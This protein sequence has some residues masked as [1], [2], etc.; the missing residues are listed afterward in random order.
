MR[1]KVKVSK[2]G[3]HTKRRFTE[4]RKQNVDLLNAYKTKRRHYKTSTKK[5]STT[6]KRQHFLGEQN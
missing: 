2:K 5:T 3:A 1:Q 6:T 4:R